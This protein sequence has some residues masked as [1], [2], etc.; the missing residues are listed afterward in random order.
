MLQIHNLTIRL[1][2]D[3]RTVLQDFSFSLNQGDKAAIIGE[4]G[5]GKSTLIKL[6][7]DPSFMEG[8]AEYDGS[9]YKS[10]TRTGYLPQELAPEFY[11]MTVFQ[12]GETY[13]NHSL[14]DEGELERLTSELGLQVGF[15][16]SQQAVS[17]LSGGERIKLQLLSVLA[18]KPDVL[19]FDEPTNDID[20]KT[21]EWL[22]SFISNCRLPIMFVSHDETL[23]DRTANIII[24]IEQVRRK[25][26]CRHTISKIT[27]AQYVKERS[28]RLL[29]QTQLARKEKDEYTKKQERWQ[30]IYNKVEHAQN[31]V[32]RQ[33]PSTGRLLKKKMKG[34]KS[35]EKHLEWEK[36][37]MTQLPDVEDAIMP[38]F[39]VI[40]PVPSGK[41]ILKLSIDELRVQATPD[42]RIL[43]TNILLEVYGPEHLCI[44]GRNGVGK[45]TLLRMIAEDLSSRKDI[46]AG[47]M[48]QNYNEKLYAQMSP[49]D[50]LAPSGH[51]DDITKARTYLGSMKF[52][53][54]EMLHNVTDLSGGQRAKLLL[55][56]LILDGCNVLILDEPTRNFSPISSPIILNI[57]KNFSGTIISVSH[58]RKYIKEVCTKVLE[59]TENGIRE[60]SI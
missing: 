6:L 55:T 7:H 56:K 49:V 14:L 39:N 32:S 26:V 21:L 16:S 54:D 10:G 19:L 40:A 42:H 44:I 33:D 5:N 22:E 24:H 51:R 47:Y 20:I 4:E 27:Y 29:H 30:Q 60:T 25:T 12:F 1:T 34:M 13:I 3:L 52:T 53:S 58:D 17:T 57:L 8:Y 36:E 46:K 35:Q 43:S 2:K 15:L 48:A 37:K 11:S 59:L 23:L 50:F 9:I 18:Q 28:S 38:D 41:T 45:T 31:A